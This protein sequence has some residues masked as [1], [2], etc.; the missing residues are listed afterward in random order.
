MG[1]INSLGGQSSNIV[2]SSGFREIQA[3][4]LKMDRPD[5]FRFSDEYNLSLAWGVPLIGF[6]IMAL[7]FLIGLATTDV[8]LSEWVLPFAALGSFWLVWAFFFV[9]ITW[10]HRVSDKRAV[11]RMFEDGIWEHWQFRYPEWQAIVDAECDLISPKGEGLEPYVGAVYSSI[12][13][14]VFAAIMIAVGAFAIQ[15]PQ[16]KT[17]LNICAV[18]VFLLFLGVGLFQPVLARYKARRYRLKALRVLKP[19]VWFASEGIYHETLG[20]TSLDDLIK[21]TD[22]TT[23]RKEIQFTLYIYKAFKT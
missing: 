3:G 4:S 15:D 11:N 7:S 13:G 20:Y 9:F 12:F 16:G 23:S 19:R 10:I 21:V 8:N 22:Q 2:C 14:I 18:A 6:A 5:E 17:A 1:I